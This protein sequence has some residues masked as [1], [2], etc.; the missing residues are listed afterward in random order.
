MAN[1]QRSLS[2]Q[3]GAGLFRHLLRLPL[4]YFEKRHI[5]D[6]VSRFGSTE[7]IRHVLSEGLITALIDG[8]MTLFTVTMIFLYAPTLALIVIGALS[9]YVLLRMAFYYRLRSMSLDLM[10][11]RASEGSTFIETMRA[12][13]GI[14]LFN[15]Q[16]ERGAVWM[17]RYAE[18]VRADTEIETAKQTFH[19]AND[20]I[21]GLENI[22]I[23]Y[24]AAHA[25][26]ANQMTVGMLFAF[27]AYKQQFVSK[28]S[29]LVE[30]AI[31][32]RMLDLHLDRLADIAGAEP[33][34][35]GPG[36]TAFPKP[37][38]G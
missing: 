22:L 25:V 32:F 6:L 3:M 5:G 24:L 21:F 9:L 38:R 2:F 19:V 36:R 11:A 16:V 35:S 31:E 14:K 34:Q 7:P 28:A 37:L 17:N 23:V 33:E 10:A 8:L 29:T 15:R 20:L 26:L 18:V 12:I 13:Q 4:S 30:K 27:M 1:V